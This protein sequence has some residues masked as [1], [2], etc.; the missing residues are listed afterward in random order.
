MMTTR[1]SVALTLAAAI[2]LA[3]LAPISAMAQGGC[4]WYVKISL[5]QQSMNVAK[6][7]HK[8]GPQWSASREVHQKFCAS[9]RPVVWKKVAQMRKAE[10]DNNCK[11]K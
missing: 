2:G 10:L 5:K 11:A 3:G 4:D 1:K 6:G 7:C 9:V 8:T